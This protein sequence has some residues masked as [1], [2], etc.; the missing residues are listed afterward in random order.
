MNNCRSNNLMFQ[1]RPFISSL[2]IHQKPCKGINKQFIPL[3]TALCVNE[4]CRDIKPEILVEHIFLCCH[5]AGEKNCP[6]WH[7]K[8]QFI[9]LCIKARLTEKLN[10]LAK[11]KAVLL[12]GCQTSHSPGRAILAR[13]LETFHYRIYCPSFARITSPQQSSAPSAAVI[14]ATDKSSSPCTD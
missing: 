14:H 8:S 2:I 4:K 6:L 7:H 10:K 13:Y 11:H 5:S 3:L 1:L 9:E 12:T